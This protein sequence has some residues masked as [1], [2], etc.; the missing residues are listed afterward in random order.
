MRR[1]NKEEDSGKV[2]RIET[3][4][5]REIC[6]ELCLI[7]ETRAPERHPEPG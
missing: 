4:R 2:R 1:N 7:D 3:E 5:E 6:Q